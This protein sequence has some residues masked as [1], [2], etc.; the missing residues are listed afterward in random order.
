MVTV[1]EYL[2]MS[3]DPLWYGEQDASGVDLSL[4]RSNLQLTPRERLLRGDRARRN[5]LRLLDYGRQQRES[6]ERRKRS[7][8][9]RGDSAPPPG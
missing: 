7:G 9:D 3:R 6:N 8:E 4:I 2:K 1:D 5:A